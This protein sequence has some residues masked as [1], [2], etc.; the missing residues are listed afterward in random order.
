MVRLLVVVVLLAG[1]SACVKN[2]VTGKRQLSLVSERDEIALGQEAKGQIVQ[3][4]GLVQD[5]ALQAYVSEIGMRMAKDSER[6]KLPWSFQVID[7]AAVNA[8]ALPG[9]P[10]F[11]TRG[12]LN[13]LN[14]EAELAIVLG[15]EI[16]HVTAKHSVAMISKAQLTQLGLGVGTILL[17]EELRGLGQLAGAGASLLFLKYGRDAERQSDELGFK[18][19]LS[20][21]YDVRE[22]KDVFTTLGN[23]SAGQ[24]RLPEWLSTHPNPENRVETAQEL[25]KETRGVNYEQLQTDRE[26]YLS[27]LN[28]LV[29]GE[30][31]R[32][33]FFQG[34]AFL[35]PDLEFRLDFPAGWKAMNT[36]SAVVGV[37]P[38]ED[39]II[40]LGHAGNLTP[41]AAAQKFFSTPGVRR[42]DVSVGRLNP[43]PSVAGYFLAET[44][45]GPVGG[46]AAFISHEGKTLQL[47]GYTPAQLLQTYDATLRGAIA[48]FSP[49]T[50]PQAL[51]VQPAKVEIVTLPSEMT[52]GDFN[53]QFPSTVPLKTIS[54]I[55]GF[56]PDARLPAGTKLKRVVGGTPAQTTNQ[57]SL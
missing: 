48:S 18:Y 13:H 4:I 38:R 26:E 11:I 23:A 50:D 28:G 25:L 49:L 40:Q 34:N 47:I 56:A 16:G 39:A 14:S 10:I 19:A 5:P 8:F 30:N 3:S 57:A 6:P 51:G 24:G 20:E 29:F 37:S 43:L 12:I 33:G 55:N 27:H 1:A 17:P 21:R 7:D 32:N 36:P 9:G 41:E 35:H 46:I 53:A 45:Q 44:E 52:L 54:L 15:H 42:G 2:P 31:P 22:M